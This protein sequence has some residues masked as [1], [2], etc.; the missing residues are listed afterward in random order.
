MT[1]PTTVVYYISLASKIFETNPKNKKMK[2]TET[3]LFLF[4][5]TKYFIQVVHINM[6]KA[7]LL[8]TNSLIQL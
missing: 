3:L 4:R 1:K 8:Q 5:L 6:I 7:K 2:I